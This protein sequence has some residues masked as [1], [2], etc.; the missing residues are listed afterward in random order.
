MYKGGMLMDKYM[1]LVWGII[2]AVTV[3][4]EIST[5]QMVSIWFAISA[6]ISLILAWLGTPVWAQIAV[7]IAVTVILLIFTKDVAKKIFNTTPTNADMDIGK[8]AIV[9]EEINNERQVGRAT[10]AGVSWAARSQDGSIIPKDAIVTIVAI[11]STKL[12]VK[13]Q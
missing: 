4:A 11:D 13:I 2:L 5:V 1:M 6:L 3:I 10:L 8:T 12:I 7:F 9:T